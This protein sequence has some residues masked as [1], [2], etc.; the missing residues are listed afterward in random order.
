VNSNELYDFARP[1]LAKIINI[2]G[3]GMKK[4]DAKPLKPEFSSRVDK[5]KG[6][7]VMS[8]GSFAPMYLMPDHWKD[9]YFHAFA[10]FPD[11]QFFIRYENPDD[12]TD[13]LPPN[14]YAST[15]LP[16]T[17]LLQH[18]KCLGL[19]SHGGY[20]SL[21]EVIHAGVPIIATAL[22]GDQSKNAHL[23][24]R[25]GLGINLHKTTMNRETV[26]SAVRRLIEDESLK[27]AAVRLR[28]MVETKPISAE[29]LLV[30]WMEFVAEHKNLDNLTP[31]GAQLNLLVYHSVD[32]IAFLA[33]VVFIVLSV[34]FLL[35]RFVYRKCRNLLRRRVDEEKKQQ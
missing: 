2:G 28:S 6:I 20:N 4:K 8:F 11:V 19:I 33:V 21:Q 29:T 9:A 24:V 26:T 23:A 25:L 32:V 17:D 7:V 22:F 16:Q 31:Y 34:I 3:I 35:L 30:R 18:P 5:A 10:Q 1:T 27:K 13:R 12:I 15:W 14:V